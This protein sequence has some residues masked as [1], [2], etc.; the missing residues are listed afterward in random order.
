MQHKRLEHIPNV[1][2]RHVAQLRKMNIHTTQQLLEVCSTVEERYRLAEK[3][4]ISELR[5]FDWVC[6]IDLFRISGLHS[7]YVTLLL[8]A[9]INS[10]EKIATQNAPELAAQLRELNQT[11][12]IVRRLPSERQIEGWIVAARGL[13]PLFETSR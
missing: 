5:V 3:L 13:P 2:F 10:A 4:E 7:T 1:T 12:R 11:N 8:E 6:A 9:G